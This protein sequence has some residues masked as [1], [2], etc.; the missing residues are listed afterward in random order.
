VTAVATG[1]TRRI[2]EFVSGTSIDRIPVEAIEGAK[3]SILDTL[4]CGVAAL[5]Q[6]AA[7]TILDY[8]RS[9]AGA[10]TATV[11]GSEALTAPPLAALA[12]GCL[13]N[14]LDYDGFFHAPTHTLTS[15]L[16]TGELVG[17]TGAQV[18]EAYIAGFEVAGRLREVIE[19]Q[20]DA[21][22]GPTYRGWY[23]VSLYGPLASAM[24]AGKLLGLDVQGLEG[25]LGAA[26]CGAG[27]V[28]ENLGARAKSYNSGNSARVGVEAA[29]LAQR[30]IT[31]AANILE[32]R[33]GLIN[34]VCL[35]GECDWAPIETGLTSGYR[36][37]AAALSTKRYPAVGAVQGMLGALE[38]LR[39]DE[40]FTIDDIDSV[41]A[42][43]STFAASLAPPRDELEAGFAWPSLLAAVLVNGSF[44]VDHLSTTL[45]KQPRF[46]A[47]IDKLHFAEPEKG[48]RDRVAVHLK[49]GRVLE[50]VSDAKLGRVL[51]DGMAAKYRDCARRGLAE[52]EVEQLFEQ[53]MQM[54]R[55]GSIADITQ[56]LVGARPR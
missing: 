47:A 21:E 46:Q 55:I 9:L 6:P 2:A 4:G 16:A 10:P 53:V 3:L 14:L 27:G 38:Q 25:A 8:V 52:S 15:A 5:Q 11:L 1:P 19:A 24:A 26:A 40:G 49:G 51:R 31:G 23:H 20:R 50:A 42:R 7:L 39:S 32:A 18:L 36:L 48:A 35:E 45:F 29:L 54:E 56:L 37:A 33:F 17:A 22:S 44:T 34:A 28:R 13:V 30:G 43:V 12:N 41:D